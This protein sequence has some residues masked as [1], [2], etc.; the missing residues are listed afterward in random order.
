MAVACGTA[1][2]VWRAVWWFHGWVR[3]AGRWRL[4]RAH[5]RC[6]RLPPMED[7]PPDDAQSTPPLQR[8]RKGHAE[9]RDSADFSTAVA[10]RRGHA[11][12]R[13]PAQCS[14]PVAANRDVPKLGIPPRVPQVAAARRGYADVRDPAQCSTLAA[15]RRGWATLQR[16]HGRRQSCG[17]RSDGCW[18]AVAAAG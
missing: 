4:G 8:Q 2:A 13:D 15:A 10:A 7:L 11:E 18:M 3:T 12:C 6:L 5:G 16:P 9:V 1:M 17:M 14:T